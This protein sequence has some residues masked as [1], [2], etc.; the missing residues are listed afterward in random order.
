MPLLHLQ[1]GWVFPE[2]NVTCETGY[3]VYCFVIDSTTIALFLHDMK[4]SSNPLTF[5][6]GGAAILMV[7][8]FSW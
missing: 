2:I 8:Y 7:R 3:Q 6:P 5:V 1:P 4:H